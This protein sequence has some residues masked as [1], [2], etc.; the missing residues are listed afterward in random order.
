M[1]NDS[2][3]ETRHTILDVFE[4][5]LVEVR[6]SPYAGVDNVRKALTTGHLKPAVERPLNSNTFGR[7][8]AVSGYSSDER[9]QFVSLLLQLLDER[10]DGS[11]GEALTLSSLSVAHK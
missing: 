10:L 7:M 6:P 8:G 4:F 1:I 5:I 2:P 9:I 3:N 11:L